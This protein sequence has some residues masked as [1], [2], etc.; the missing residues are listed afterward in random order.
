MRY[1]REAIELKNKVKDLNRQLESGNV[2]NVTYRHIVSE[3]NETLYAMDEGNKND[4]AEIARLEAQIQDKET[5][6]WERDVA[7]Q[8]VLRE[9]AIRSDEIV[10]QQTFIKNLQ[11]NLKEEKQ[12]YLT[13]VLR[14][15]LEDAEK[16]MITHGIRVSGPKDHKQILIEELE[17]LV[18]AGET[19]SSAYISKKRILEKALNI[20]AEVDKQRAER[21]NIDH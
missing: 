6:L 1:E 16:K 4:K 11:D 10:A 15:R 18:A 19:Q 12:K 7:N 2:A 8:E 9:F 5:Q 13:R 21:V 17:H 14:N 3:Q 20:E